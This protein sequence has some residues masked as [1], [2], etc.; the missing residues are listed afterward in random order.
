MTSFENY[1]QNIHSVIYG[2]TDDDMPDAFENWLSNLDGEDYMRYGQLY[3]EKT[4]LEG[5]RSLLDNEK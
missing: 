3:G 5:H 4:F 1:L 2:G